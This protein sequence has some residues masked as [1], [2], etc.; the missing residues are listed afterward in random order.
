MLARKPRRSRISTDCALRSG[1][2][3][4]AGA[5]Q[6]DIDRIAPLREAP[7]ADLARI[8]EQGDEPCVFRGLVGDWP[9]VAQAKRGPEE[10]V[11]Y[12][13]GFDKGAVIRAFVGEG[14]IDG[15]F[16][17]SADFGRFNFGVVEARLDKLLE[18]LLE[19]RG[20]DDESIYMGST[21]TAQ[22]LPDFGRSN[23]LPLVEGRGGEPRIWIGNGSR[24]AAHFDES[25]NVA[26]VVGGK[27]RFTLFPPEQVG[28]LYV[29]PLDR[30]P[31]GQPTSMVD[32]AAPDWTRFPRFREAIKHARSSELSPGDAIYIPALWWHSIEASGRLNVLVNFW[33]QDEPLDADSPLHALAHALLSISHLLPRKRARWRVLFDHYVFKDHGE[34][35]EHIPEQ[36]RG[37]LGPTSPELRQFIR[38]YLVRKLMGR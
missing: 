1:R 5:T 15:R 26:C 11:D 17:Y 8:I 7:P 31:A 37:I 27:R 34:P 38:Q 32:L 6:E 12:L 36:A 22:I 16:F 24:I 29:G 9:V 10:L 30:T 4:G 18:R 14:R 3:V 21:P 19:L 28:N 23:P 35:A 20:R 2:C 33:W 25:D 13:R